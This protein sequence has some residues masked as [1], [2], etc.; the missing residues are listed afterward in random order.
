LPNFSA[1]ALAWQNNTKDGLYVGLNY[2]IYYIDNTFT[3]WQPFSNNLPNVIV[4]ELEINEV[5]NKIYAGTYGRGLWASSTFDPTLSNKEFEL[6][7]ISI[8]PNPASSEI[9]LK[10][11]KSNDVNIKVFN[12]LGKLLYSEFNQNLS[13]GFKIDTNNYSTGLYFVRVNNSN[14][15]LTKKIVIE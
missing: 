8:F 4:N 14:G 10:W 5:N 2:G 15:V 7:A 13:N 11:N 3:E 12:S 6:D 9:N 1:L